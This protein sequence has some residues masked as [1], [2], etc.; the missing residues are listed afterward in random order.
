MIVKHIISV[1]VRR[2][3]ALVFAWCIAILGGCGSCR[4]HLSL[5]VLLSN[6]E[7]VDGAAVTVRAVMAVL[8]GDRWEGRTDSKG[9]AEICTDLG[10][11]PRFVEV[12][13]EN[14]TY[15][16]IISKATFAESD[17]RVVDVFVS[18]NTNPDAT[19]EIRRCRHPR[20]N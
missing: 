17:V 10:R 13:F 19:F 6:G 14:E 7:D 12:F 18:G 3:A 8:P 16:A 2:S 15:S 1:S 20:P 4:D 9:R 5:R 11:S